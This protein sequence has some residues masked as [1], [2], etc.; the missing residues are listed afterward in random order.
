MMAPLQRSLTDGHASGAEQSFYLQ[1]LGAA[2]ADSLR[3]TIRGELAWLLAP[4]MHHMPDALA[5]YEATA[6]DPVLR[7]SVRELRR[8]FEVI[9][10]RW[11]DTFIYAVDTRLIGSGAAPDEPGASEDL[12]AGRAEL[13]AEEKYARLLGQLDD[14]LQLIRRTLYVPVHVRALAPAGLSRA[15]QDTAEQLGWPAAHRPFLFARF[16]EDVLLRLGE[17]YRGLLV[18]LRAIGSTA[19]QLDAQRAALPMPEQAART[20]P[21]VDDGTLSMLRNYA[22]KADDRLYNDH[23]LA[24]DLLALAENQSIPDLPQE[25]RHAPLQRMSAAGQFLSEAIADPLLPEE[26]RRRQDAVRL[27]L[28]KTALAD[29]TLFTSPHHPVSSLVDEMMLKAATARVTGNVE[30]RRAAERLEQLL[31]QFELAPEFVRQ[32]L[33]TQQPV[34][35][36]QVQQFMESKRLRARERRQSVLHTVQR[37]VI[38]ELRLSTFGREV[39]VPAVVLEFLHKSWAPLLM[40]GLLDHGP[41]DVRWRQDLDMVDQL[42]EMSELGFGEDDAWEALLLRLTQR[43]AMSGMRDDRIEQGIGLLRALRP[44]S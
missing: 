38:E 12:V 41:N 35:E 6:A 19:Q 30:E 13:R 1:R 43:M 8:L 5:E 32:A 44:G 29:A 10:G 7:E 17:L 42:V 31:V 16:G 15:L 28:V 11:V 20:E 40:K 22:A 36:A 18:A 23:A 9:S 37:R 3:R 4:F 14:R 25:Q 21:K 34:D 26:L 24:A 2:A 27:P 33:L 39:D